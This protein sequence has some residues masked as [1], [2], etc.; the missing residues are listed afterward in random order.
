MSTLSLYYFYPSFLTF[1][2]SQ[3]GFF[4]PLLPVL[5]L[6]CTYSHFFPTHFTPTF[7]GRPLPLSLLLLSPFSLPLAF[8]ILSHSPF[9][10]NF[11]FFFTFSSVHFRFPF[12]GIFFFPFSSNSSVVLG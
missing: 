5:P 4:F 9:S 1:F 3:W 11:L 12:L 2:L 7:L 8:S 6:S 10:L